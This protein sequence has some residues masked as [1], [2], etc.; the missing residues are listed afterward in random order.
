MVG[1]EN[2]HVNKNLPIDEPWSCSQKTKET[3]KYTNKNTALLINTPVICVCVC[4]IFILFEI[5]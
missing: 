3:P 5:V 1:A 4:D 2:G